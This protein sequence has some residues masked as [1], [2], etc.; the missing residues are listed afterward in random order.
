MKFSVFSEFL[1][2]DWQWPVQPQ[3]P[4]DQVR[5][6]VFMAA[7]EWPALWKRGTVTDWEYGLSR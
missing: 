4:R 3:T 2:P 7:N 5:F 6:A 1:P